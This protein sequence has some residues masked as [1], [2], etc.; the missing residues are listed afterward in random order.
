VQ[1]EK[2]LEVLSKRIRYWF[3]NSL[4]KKGAFSIWV[5]LAILAGAL[6]IAIAQAVLSSVAVL[7]S[8]V[9]EASNTFEAFWYSLGKMLS[10]GAGVTYADRIMS[11]VYWFAGLT[12]AGSIFAFRSVA[13]N[14]TIE[15]MKAAPSPI[16]DS[17]HTL[18]LGWSP[19]VFTILDELS[20]ANVNVRK[21][22]VVI[23]ANQDRDYMDLEISKRTGNLGNLRVITR[24]GDTTNPKDLLRANV[25]GA[26][27]VI[28]LDSDRSGDSMIV[29]TVLAARSISDNPEQR[30]VA[31]VDDPNVAEALEASTDGQVISVIPRDV[32]SKVTAQ[33]SRQPGIPSVILELLDFAGEEL[34]FAAV[35]ELV[36]KT[37]FEAQLSFNNSA[38]IGIVPSGR[39]PVL[40]PSHDYMIAEDD[41]LIAIA[42]D[43]DKVIYSGK[44]DSPSRSRLEKR[45][46][47]VAKARNLLVIGWSEMGRSVLGELAEFLPKGSTVDVVLQERFI[48]ETLE[49]DATIGSLKVRYIKSTGRFDQLEGLVK[50]K[51]YN[52]VLVLGYRGEN[53]TESEADGHTLLAT[54]ELSR[55]FSEELKAGAAPRVVAEILN[56]LKV[57]LAQSSSADDLVVSE[58]LVAL[59]VTQLSENPH[60]ASI[61]K[62]LFDPTK[63]SAIHVRPLT[64]Y[65]AAGK[66]VSFAKLIAAASSRS[67][68][69]I[70]WRVSGDEGS[71][72]NVALNPAKDKVVIPIEGDGLIVI[73]RSI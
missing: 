58:N 44:V 10:L 60:L 65:S 26:K 5:V 23:F 21:P 17:G 20:Q 41:Q 7:A 64:D 13:L 36:G 4:S 50:K 33:A 69:A 22:L 19:R 66:S 28:V 1:N 35:P 59:L 45:A 56:P 39:R 3:D 48:E 43:D 14:K 9:P 2:Y 30:F 24:K 70:G 12:V 67:E 52:E 29:S 55:L 6:V 54:M 34:Y 63:G 11:I 16:L 42:E 31:E 37:Y 47:T 68:T 73:G 38:I 51:R 40:N 8:P 61:F 27:S 18:I 46:R 15:R 62:D 25:A 49:N 71:A 32:I 57:E 53:I 72:R